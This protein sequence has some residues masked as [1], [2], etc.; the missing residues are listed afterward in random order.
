MKKA[1]IARNEG[2]RIVQVENELNIFPVSPPLVWIECPDEVTI[3]Y[4]YNA[5]SFIPPTPPQVETPQPKFEDKVLEALQTL[6]AA[7]H[8]PNLTIN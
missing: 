8:L 2:N 6:K 1:L 4:V 3:R 5:G 7:G